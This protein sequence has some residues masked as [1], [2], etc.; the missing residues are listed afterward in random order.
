MEKTLEDS[1]SEEMIL[2]KENNRLF[3]TSDIAKDRNSGKIKLLPMSPLAAS[4]TVIN[5]ILATGPFTYP[6]QFASLGPVFSL[7]FL[8]F[9]AIIS[10][11]TSTFIIEAISYANALKDQHRN[12]TLFPDNSYQSESA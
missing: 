12:D 9:T 10:Y 1:R 7:A 2:P 8:F 4:A 5:L 11:I 6:S 3:D